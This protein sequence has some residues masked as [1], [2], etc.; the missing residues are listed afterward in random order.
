[1]RDDLASPTYSGA[2]GDGLI[3]RWSTPADTE[4]FAWLM[5]TVFRNENDVRATAREGEGSP[6]LSWAG[7]H[8][9]ACAL[10]PWVMPTDFLRDPYALHVHCSISRG[11]AV[12]WQGEASTTALRP[13]LDEVVPRLARAQSFPDGAYLLARVPLA[14]PEPIGLRA[15]GSVEVS[16]E[17]LGTLR[18]PVA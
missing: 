6:D 10:G 7:T 15:G 5:G 18:N 17:E 11:V 16:I 1:M 4:K 13:W 2:L 12:L 8:N 14:P 9:G 3:R